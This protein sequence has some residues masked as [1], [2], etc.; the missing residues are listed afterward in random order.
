MRVIT[1]LLMV[2]ELLM[3]TELFMVTD[4]LMVSET[5]DFILRNLGYNQDAVMCKRQ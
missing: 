1:S 3:V 5:S 4:I 2:I